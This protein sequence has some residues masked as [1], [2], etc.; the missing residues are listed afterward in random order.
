MGTLQQLKREYGVVDCFDLGSTQL[1]KLRDGLKNVTPAEVTSSDDGKAYIELLRKFREAVAEN[2]KLHGDN[3]PALLSSILSVG[4]DGLYS[5]SLRFIFELIQNV[6]DCEYHSP[7]DCSL[8]MYFDFNL[9]KIVLTYNEVGFTPFNVFA[10]TGIAEAAKNVSSSGNEI[11]EKGIGF[12]SVFGVSE[13]VLI[14]SG[15]FSFELYKENFTI[16][17]ASYQN[18]EYCPGTEMTLYVPKRAKEIYREIKAQ[19]CS[20][21]ALFSRNPLLFLNKLTSLKMYFDVW[22][23]MEFHVS[24]SGMTGCKAMEVERD[25]E[26]S[27]NLRDHDANGSDVDVRESITCSRYSY[28]VVFTRTACQARYGED[29]QVGFPNGKTMILRVVLPNPEYIQDVGM[30]ALYSF[31]PTQLKLTVPMVCHVP[32]KL[33]ASREFVDPQGENIW[34]KEASAHLTKLIDYAYMD[35]RSVVKE[36]IVHYIPGIRRNLFAQNNGKEKCLSGQRSFSGKH[37]LDF[38]LFFCSDGAYHRADEVFCFNTEEKIAEPEKVYRLMGYQK[39]LFLSPKAVN[40]FDIHTEQNVKDHLLRRAFTAPA[41]TGEIL[42]YLDHAEYVYSEKDIP[43][44]C[45]FKLRAK[46]L[47]IIFRH[48][49]LAEC[50][51]KSGCGQVQDNR[52]PAFSVGVDKL[53]ELQDVLYENFDLNETPGQVEKY[54]TYC[55]KKCICLDIN[56]DCFLPCQNAIV[57]SKNNPMA[58]FASFCYAID[59]KS[60][61]AIR[62]KLREASER[63]NQYVEEGVGSAS[64]YLRDLRNIR[65]LIKESLGNRGYSSYINLILR[66]GTEKGRFIQEILQNADDCEYAPD[67]VPT[68]VLNQKENIIQTQYN[69]VGFNRANIRAITAIGE[70]TKNLLLNN[71]VHTIGEKGVGFKSIFAVASEVKIHSGDYSFSLTDREPTIPRLLK[72]TEQS[73]EAGTK[74]ELVLRDKSVFPDLTD[75]TILELCLCLRKLRSI[76]IG[77]HSVLIEDTDGQRSITIDKRKHVFRRFTHA[78]TVSDDKALMERR[79]GARAITPEQTI[80]CFVPKTGTSDFPLYNGLPTKHKIKIPMAIDAPFALTTSREEIETDSSR[81]NN[82]IREE[83]YTAILK[84][85]DTL[86]YEERE[87]VLRF[88]RFVPRFKGSVRVYVNDISDSMYLAQYDYLS[89]LKARNILPTLDEK[90]FAIPQRKEAFRFP[91]VSRILFGKVSASQYAGIHPSTVIDV[92]GKDHEAALN[93]LECDTAAFAQAFSIVKMHAERYIWDEK[94]RMSLFEFLEKADPDFREQIKSMAIIP[95]YGKTPGTVDYIPWKDDS[96]FIKKGTGVSAADYYVLNEKILSKASCEKI[97]GSN[98][99]EMNDEWERNRYN[100]RLKELL[101]GDDIT[102]IYYDLLEENRSGALRKNESFAI[103]NA[104]PDKVPMKNELGKIVRS[105]L[106]ICDEPAGY[107]PVKMMQRL[108]V[109][110]ECQN[111]ARFM[112]IRELSGIHYNELDYKEVLTADDIECLMDEYFVNSEEI[113]RGF[114][115][116]GLLPEELLEEYGLEYIS[117]GRTGGEYYEF[118]TDAIKDRNSLVKHVKKLLTSPAKIVSVKVER[119][120]QKGESADGTMFEL[121]ARDAR[122]GALRT[123]MPEGTHNR[124]FCQMCHQVKPYRL[125]EVN[126]IEKKPKYYF[127][128]LRIALCLECSKRFE[129][130]RNNNTIRE[131]YLKDIKNASVLNQG[132]VDIA[133]GGE[134]KITFTG[135]HLAEIQEILN[136]IQN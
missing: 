66:S 14:R 109:H 4:E 42:D 33:D 100:K 28:P 64:D 15:W 62:L 22:R 98:I 3:Y 65:L 54:M 30:G 115:K 23:S 81:W 72:S 84:V 31:L 43:K 59:K 70:S 114:Y 103:L 5:N 55:H 127:P 91:E 45:D 106:F 101:N 111:F 85:I 24:R 116:D 113:L 97:M 34:F 13:K 78:F 37:Y 36:N 26:I 71:D 11:G 119:T 44:E 41:H 87:K 99:N 93:A 110:K 74:M 82:I 47:E 12:K 49:N 1:K 27:V 86:K 126:N 32:F 94:F 63:L 130:M 77:D 69:E 57:L 120:V 104:D 95:V 90:I 48:T 135:R 102:E 80:T 96:I 10:I 51:Q 83:L 35:W 89:K 6:D 20:K 2:D 79:N 125:M 50:I 128:Q 118:P 117:V 8:D 124:C 17:V 123:Y 25:V 76:R 19:Y 134:D 92:T 21:E 112:K 18:T 61:F 131:K 7:E 88:M 53:Q 129:Y 105:R 73:S 52:R 136:Q 38:P 39:Y 132:T 58:S 68:F 133:I 46:Q 40:Q 29:T 9:D 108:I 121:N 107:F 60:T 75:K 56:E 122:E 16:P 67:V